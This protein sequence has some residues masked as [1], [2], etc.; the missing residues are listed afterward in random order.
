MPAPPPADAALYLRWLR[1]R[2]EEAF[3]VLAEAHADL[4]LDVAWRTSGDR[5]RA[6]DAVQEALLSLALDG[7]RRPAD[8]GVRAW[9]ARRAL[10]WGRNARASD[11]ARARRERRAGET[12]EASVDAM[13]AESVEAVRAALARIDG[14]DAAVLTLRFL[15]GMEYRELA[16]VLETAEATARVRVHRATAALR[17]AMGVSAPEASDDDDRLGRVVGAIPAAGLS[18]AVRGAA[19]EG[20]I[21][22]A[23]GVPAGTG[24][25]GVGAAAVGRTAALVAAAL[26]VAGV[27]VFAVRGRGEGGGGRVESAAGEASATGGGAPPTLAKR[28]P[29]ADATAPGTP[30]G[31]ASGAASRGK[32]VRF[33]MALARSKERL[34]VSQVAVTGGAIRNFDPAVVEAAAVVKPGEFVSVLTHDPR[35]ALRSVEVRVPD[36]APEEVVV[37]VPDADDPRLKEPVFRVVDRQTK[38]PLARAVLEPGPE[39]VDVA[40]MRAD[41]EGRIR[42]PAGVAERFRPGWLEVG[43]AFTEPDHE[44]R[45]YP[46]LF[47]AGTSAE[48]VAAWEATGESV[49]ELTALEGPVPRRR[50][51]VRRAD[52]EPAA[53]VLLELRMNAIIPL[54][55]PVFPART[56]AEGRVEIVAPMVFVLDVYDAG[57]LAGS[58]VLTRAGT[59]EGTEREIRLRR[60]RT[61]RVEVEGIPKGA[62]TY[63][64]VYEAELELL[65]PESTTG[66]AWKKGVREPG[67][68]AFSPAEP[69]TVVASGEEARVVDVPVLAGREAILS[70]SFEDGGGARAVRISGDGP[71][72]VRVSWADLS[73]PPPFERGY[74]GWSTTDDPEPTPVPAPS[75]APARPRPAGK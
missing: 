26:V 60:R 23:R 30:A 9:L 72:E 43:A 61:V 10:S 37:T 49:V 12:G 54:M 1:G 50:L 5:P 17:A 15:H 41:E 7:T 33:G 42:V 32:E 56:D 48:D 64:S 28:P 35:S 65:D 62:K 11:A 52:G 8:V 16:A 19:V 67:W 36:P 20:A 51:R 66:F 59:A 58:Y 68:K 71:A 18:A 69:L 47:R 31:D 29:P 74:N 45:G 46:G 3:R 13:D 4:V 24:A 40:P 63:V 75:P 21:S 25:G 38:A 14:E 2:D 53:G 55:S 6:E 34:A 44:P 73:A 27:A 70:V 57:G 22:G 39:A